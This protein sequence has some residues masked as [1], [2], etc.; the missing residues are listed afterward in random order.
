[1]T[2]WLGIVFRPL[3][4]TGNPAKLILN[5]TPYGD[6]SAWFFL[7]S[8]LKMKKN[9]NERSY[10][11]KAKQ[12]HNVILTLFG[13]QQRSYTTLEQHRVLLLG[14]SCFNCLSFLEIACFFISIT[15]VRKSKLWYKESNLFQTFIQSS[16]SPW[17]CFSLSIS[18]FQLWKMYEPT[19]NIR[20]YFML[21][22]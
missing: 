3:F 14:S 4:W 17:L 18:L 8:F 11:R 1:M 9:E 13:R 10:E 5:R 15:F 7:I 12:A 21:I 6:L 19:I 20:I 22:K 2:F 16:N